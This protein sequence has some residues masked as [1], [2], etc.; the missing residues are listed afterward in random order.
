M[1]GEREVPIILISCSIFLN[2]VNALWEANWL[3]H[4]LRFQSSM[5][6]MHPEQLGPRLRSLVER[7]VQAGNRVVL[8][9]G[10]CCGL[11]A[12][13]EAM[14]GVVRIRGKNCCEILLGNEAYRRLSHEGAFFLLPEWAH[15]WHHIFGTELGLNHENA[16]SF[17]QDMH[18]KLVYLDT[19]VVPVPEA[20]LQACS[21]YCG[22]PY[23]V[24]P[25]SL[26][27]LR[28]AILEAIQR[29]EVGGNG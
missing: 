17:M 6:H 3:N 4:P 11:M 5:L 12:D 26:E 28:E 10:D 1:S 23:E 15:R 24:Y 27:H 2:E 8:L 14:P 25:V 13:M 9:Y 16:T 22:L 18:K 20:T 19:G 7:E 21:A 29:L